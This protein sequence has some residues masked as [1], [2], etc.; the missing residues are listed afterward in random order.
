MGTTMED[1]F[2]IPTSHHTTPLG[3]IGRDP[4][5][6]L[7]VPDYWKEFDEPIELLKN[8][9]RTFSKDAERLAVI[10]EQHRIPY[11]RGEIEPAFPVWLLR[12]FYPANLSERAVD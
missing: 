12:E 4:G 5:R 6:L 10:C 2:D 1:S 11:L 8:P 7:S 3:R 9:D